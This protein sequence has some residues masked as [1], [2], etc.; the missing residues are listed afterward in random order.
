MIW[1]DDTPAERYIIAAEDGLTGHDLRN[2]MPYSRPV[3]VVDSLWPSRYLTLMAQDQD[4]GGLPCILKPGQPQPRADPR[5][6]EEDKSQA[7]DR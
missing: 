3:V 5:D 4:L 6:Q 1:L 2:I 7:H